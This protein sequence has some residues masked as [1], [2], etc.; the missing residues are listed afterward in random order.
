MC[1]FDFVQVDWHFCHHSIPAP[2]PLL[3]K[4]LF[5]ADCVEAAWKLRVVSDHFQIVHF[6]DQAD[7]QIE[8]LFCDVD[9]VGE[10]WQCT[11]WF[12]VF[13]ICVTCPAAAWCF[14]TFVGS[15][16]AEHCEALT[17]GRSGIE[18]ENFC[19]HW[20]MH[21][22][23]INANRAFLSVFL[24]RICWYVDVSWCVY[25]NLAITWAHLN[26]FGVFWIVF[27]IRAG[28]EFSHRIYSHWKDLV[29]DGGFY[30]IPNVDFK[31]WYST[32]LKALVVKRWLRQRAVWNLVEAWI[33]LEPLFDWNFV[34]AVWA[35]NIIKRCK[36]AVGNPTDVFQCFVCCVLS[37]ECSWFD[38]FGFGWPCAEN[39]KNERIRRAFEKKH[40]KQC[41]PK[42][43][44]LICV[45]VFM[46]FGCL[47]TILIDFDGP[48][49][50][51]IVLITFGVVGLGGVGFL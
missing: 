38:W 17:E 48:E 24:R 51:W 34:V 50:N 19:G 9:F 41:E 36:T 3:Q 12:P 4:T 20:G 21:L 44:N 7:A 22:L 10:F 13:R 11:A 6:G 46:F 35:K 43:G 23:S 49:Y 28:F 37:L 29:G 31:A 25:F 27:K 32:K 18:T 14:T 47:W 39:K 1:P 45:H 26:D 30:K 40:V 33:G 15:Q 42:C 8:G 16:T 2:F 5:V